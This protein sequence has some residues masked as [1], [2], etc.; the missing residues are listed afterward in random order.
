VYSPEHQRIIAEGTATDQ[1]KKGE[2]TR[3]YGTD[4]YAVVELLDTEMNYTQVAEIKELSDPNKTQFLN[5][6]RVRNDTRYSTVKNDSH[7]YVTYTIDDGM[8]L[9]IAQ[10]LPTVN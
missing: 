2:Q 5:F 8:Y 4:K 7:I 1:L 3:I 10:V 6:T 9:S